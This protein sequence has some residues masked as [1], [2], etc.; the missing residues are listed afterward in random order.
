MITMSLILQTA[1]SKM[2]GDDQNI[3]YISHALK[4]ES[5]KCMTQQTQK[6][7]CQ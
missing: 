5:L 6:N 1:E 4:M 2:N 7:D 3:V